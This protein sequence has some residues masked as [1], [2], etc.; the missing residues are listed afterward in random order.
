MTEISGANADQAAY[1]NDQAGPTWAAMQEIMDWQLA[2][3][4]RAVIDVLQPQEGEHVLDI[5]CGAGG[6]SLELAWRIE[7]E[8]SVTG[9]D[10]S[11]PLLDLARRRA[12]AAGY[13]QVRFIHGDAQA[14][15]FKAG[16]FDAA[17]SRF[18]VMF[19]ADPVAAFANIRKALRS[20]GRMAFVCW[21]AA[22]DNPLM[23]LPLQ[24]AAHLFDAP[25]AP[26]PDPR[27][28]GPFAFADGERLK[29]ILGDA[30]FTDVSLTA[31]SARI[32]SRTL[33]DALQAALRIGPLGR[34]L[35]SFPDRREAA[36]GAV[37]AALAAHEGP[38][39]VLLPSATWIVTARSPA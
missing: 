20:G 23:T 33:D 37:R 12:D 26:A 17:F 6:T 16:A 14:Q 3:L 31:H 36:I 2:P 1:W 18:G 24:A 38:D 27:A 11:E 39:G 25:P 4:S 32:G 8:G 9:V 5:G 21:R 28:P 34:M 19:F 35:N 10:V 29:A 22:A 13:A 30:G 7:P 15:A